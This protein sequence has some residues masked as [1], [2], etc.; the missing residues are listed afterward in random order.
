MLSCDSSDVSTGMVGLLNLGKLG[1]LTCKSL[2]GVYRK[3]A[4]GFNT[5]EYEFIEFGL[6][7]LLFSSKGLTFVYERSEL[8]VLA[9]TVVVDLPI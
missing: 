6:M 5:T 1:L 2:D 9:R 8:T 4:V 3:V 7:V